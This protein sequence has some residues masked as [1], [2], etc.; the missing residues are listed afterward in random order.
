MDLD[1]LATSALFLDLD[2][3]LIDIAG[4]PDAVSMPEGL[5]AL[6]SRLMRD[7]VRQRN[8]YRWAA[9]MLLDA[10]RLRQRERIDAADRV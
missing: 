3:T 4:T 8:V 2:G 7:L 1:D 9:Q 5:T 6:L 10:A